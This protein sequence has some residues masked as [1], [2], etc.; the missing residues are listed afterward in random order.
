MASPTKRKSPDAAH[1]AYNSDAA[2]TPTDA[3]PHK[4]LRVTRSQKQALIDNLQLEL[5]ERARKLRAQYALQ[6]NDLRAR[7]ERRVNRIPIALRKAK[8]GDLLEKHNTLLR[9]QQ[10]T[11]S[12]R[13]HASPGKRNVT[14]ASVKAGKRTVSAASPSTRRVKKQSHEGTYSDK[15][16]AP[17]AGESLDVLKNPKRRANPGGTSRMVSQEVRGADYRILSPKSLNSRTYPQSPFRASPEKSH[18]SNYLSRPMSPLKP[19][20]PLK[21]ASAS[22]AGVMDNARLRTTKAP[23]TTAR[24]P[25]QAQVNRPA[26]R[27]ATT[28]KTMR[29]PFSRPAT[30]LDRR[31]SIS[32]TASSGTTVV[33]P[34][35][36]GAGT[37][38]VTTTSSASA[39]V[40]RT[41][42]ARNQVSSAS[43]KKTTTSTTRKATA[44]VGGEAST[45]GRRTLRKRA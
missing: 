39:P 12:P 6:A 13:K 32:S 14:S 34:G 29:S 4:K 19:S 40:K 21:S 15:E 30:Q 41:T 33:K 11:L 26:S 17:A 44:P 27:A 10:T 24:P 42:V 7:I 28:T 18:N 5:T 22:G 23:T 3:P 36:A 45:A 31:G 16:N 37:R 2:R 8:M 9:A 38:K 20:S 1:D 43:T 35:R 25:S